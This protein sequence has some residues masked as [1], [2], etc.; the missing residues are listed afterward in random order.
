MFN[1]I[2]E[3]FMLKHIYLNIIND[4]CNGSLEF[5]VEKNTNKLFIQCNDCEVQYNSP[6]EAIDI[7]NI[8]KE[9]ER[10]KGYGKSRP[11]TLE[12]ISDAGWNEY[13]EK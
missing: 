9:I 4:C 11:A 5:R 7:N 10:Y 8:D 3:E 13:I 1:K 12:E 2:K 6:E